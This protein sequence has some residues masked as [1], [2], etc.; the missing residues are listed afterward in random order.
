[1]ADSLEAQIE[2]AVSHGLF[3]LSVTVSRSEAGAPVA[4]QATALFRRG[5][6]LVAAHTV[7]GHSILRHPVKAAERALGEGLRTIRGTPD[8]EDIFG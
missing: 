6:D 7:T 4:W 3:S 5:R 2:E 1:M 8:K